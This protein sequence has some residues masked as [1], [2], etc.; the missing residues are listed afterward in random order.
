MNNCNNKV[1]ENKA[2]ERWTPSFAWYQKVY[3]S[4]PKEELIEL[5]ESQ[6][7]KKVRDDEK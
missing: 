3:S 4:I 6:S 7:G 2:N 1:N 5:Y